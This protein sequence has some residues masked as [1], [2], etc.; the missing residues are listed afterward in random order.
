MPGDLR[1]PFSYGRV[2]SLGC[3]GTT[4]AISPGDYAVFDQQGAVPI[5]LDPLKPD[6]SRI[7]VLHREQ[8]FATMT[9]EELARMGLQLCEEPVAAT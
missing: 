6:D 4:V 1:Q 7:M 9:A 5:E 2:E 8:V 3:K